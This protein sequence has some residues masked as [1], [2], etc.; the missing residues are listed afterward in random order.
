MAIIAHLLHAALQALEL[1]M[2]PAGDAVSSAD[3]FQRREAHSQLVRH[4]LLGHMEVLRKL[5]Q[6]DR[7]R[8]H[9]ARYSA[10]VR[11]A[12][13]ALSCPRPCAS[14][15][16]RPIPFALN[17]INGSERFAALPIGVV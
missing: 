3:L 2:G 10:Q 9:V 8:R 1:A 17:F 5:L 4:V 6:R 15:D 14:L 13:R 7:Y 16:S 12:V 11:Y